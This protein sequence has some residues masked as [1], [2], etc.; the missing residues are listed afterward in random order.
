MAEERSVLDI[1]ENIDR[2]LDAKSQGDE[3]RFMAAEAL[4]RDHEHRLDGHDVKFN[5]HDERM[6]STDEVLREHGALLLKL[7]QATANAVEHAL[8][9]K[10]E[11]STT[12]D[13]SLKI[14]ESAIRLHGASIGATVTTA[15]QASVAPL[16]SEVR[17]LQ[18]GNADRDRAMTNL[19][20]EVGDIKTGV[21]NI[22]KSLGHPVLRWT[23]II[24]GALGALSG[25][26]YAAYTAH[27]AADSVAAPAPS[28][29]APK[30]APLPL[31]IP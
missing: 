28:S 30:A 16:T 31:I 5:E 25:G 2:K 22:A 13:E 1:V 9:A 19:K 15:V 29:P 14:V 17:A 12:K 7:S 4:L 8:S 26:F 21:T 3:A 18:T 24:C 6:R 11:A 20:T 23:L 10:R 27:K